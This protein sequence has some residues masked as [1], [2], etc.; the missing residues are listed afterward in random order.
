M[1]G[2]TGCFC[3]RLETTDRP[4]CLWTVPPGPIRD[5]GLELLRNLPLFKDL[6]EDLLR[7]IAPSLKVREFEEGATI[8]KEGEP[9]E[10]FYMVLEGLVVAHRNRAGLWQQDLAELGPGRP[11]NLAAAVDRARAPFSIQAAGP[12]RVLVVPLPALRTVLER[13]GRAALGVLH[14]LAAQC[15][16]LT[17]LAGDLSLLT[18]EER[19]VRYL[20]QH[21]PYQGPSA[22][23]RDR[24][25]RA[26]HGELATRLGGSREEVTRLLGRLRKKGL[27]ELGRRSVTVLSPDGLLRL[28]PRAK[29][30]VELSSVA[31]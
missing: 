22:E 4:P 17:S 2:V 18:L 11:I 24:I 13:G 30:F 15:R 19:L 26:T 6:P 1:A 3:G 25:W 20:L 5:S 27:I 28:A 31:V 7:T 29:A 9:T 16:S 23:A 12:V 21:A 10:A 14:C 8:M